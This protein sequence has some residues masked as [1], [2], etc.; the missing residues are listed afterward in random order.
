MPLTKIVQWGRSV[1]LIYTHSDIIEESYEDCRTPGFVVVVITDHG[2]VEESRTCTPGENTYM[3]NSV[4]K[5]D[6]PTAGWIRS[7]WK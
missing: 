2:S 7:H 6:T 3:N 4:N 1:T 5:S